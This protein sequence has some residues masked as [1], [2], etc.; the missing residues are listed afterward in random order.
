VLVINRE[1]E[2][3]K[4]YLY[5]DTDNVYMALM[6]TAAEIK[7]IINQTNNVLGGSSQNHD[8]TLIDACHRT[9][10]WIESA[11]EKMRWCRNNI[12]ELDEWEDI[13]DDD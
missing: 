4:S 8:K 2:R 10:V 11:M 1:K 12:S 13:G 3:V 5:S 6:K 9:L 7:N